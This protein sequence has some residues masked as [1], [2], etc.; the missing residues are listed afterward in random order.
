MLC[1][2]AARD[3][4]DDFNAAHHSDEAKE[5]MQNFFIGNYVDVSIIVIVEYVLV[6]I[7]I[8]DRAVT[9]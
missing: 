3:A 5:M 9:H 6:C 4:T 2:F 7:K 1:Y 8:L